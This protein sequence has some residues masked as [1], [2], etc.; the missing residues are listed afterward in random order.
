MTSSP[1]AV[2]LRG[3]VMEKTSRLK[4]IFRE[5]GSVLVAYSGGIDSA[6][7]ARV[8]REV[9]GDRAVAATALSPS[10]PTYEREAAERVAREIGIRHFFVET[11]ETEDPRYRA[12]GGD[13]CYFC[14][15][16]LYSVLVPLAEE[17]SLSWVV[18]GV[19]GDDGAGDRP[20]IQ[21]G[22]ER[23]VRSPLVEAGFGMKR[24]A[25]SPVNT[26]FPSLKSR[27]PPVWPPG[28]RSGS[29]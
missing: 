5:M 2:V 17:L 25:V 8:G 19:H 6:L 28:F 1:L 9:L 23:Q 29:R 22:K 14:K 21:A 12:N 20:G 11:K 15:S 7:V 27:P 10:F 4:E 16:E 26:P 3:L 18:N 13:R 24:S